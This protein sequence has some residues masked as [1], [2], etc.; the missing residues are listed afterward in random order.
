M[1][2]FDVARHILLRFLFDR[3]SQPVAAR[4]LLVGSRKPVDRGG[5]NSAA[6]PRRGI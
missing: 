5:R 4:R 3:N 2:A 1:G 6:A